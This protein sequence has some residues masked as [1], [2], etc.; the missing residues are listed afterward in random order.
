MP[1]DFAFTEEQELYRRTL[2]DYFAKVLTPK[3]KEISKARMVT[4]EVHK[5][6]TTQ[7]LLGLLV[8]KEFGGSES[9]Y[10]TFTIATEELTKA[11][12]SGLVIFGIL[13]GPVCARV[14]AAYGT[15]ELKQEVLPKVVK[16]GWIT[17]LHNTEPGCGTDF[18]DHNNR[19]E[20][21][22]GLRG[23]R[24][25]TDADR[26]SRDYEVWWRLHHNCEDET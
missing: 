4:S 7:G 5:A 13:Y 18:R 24:G 12:P 21:Q 11:D 1:L 14:I 3:S 25:E 6:M 9:D 22:W 15:A 2:K 19:E 8:P 20:D 10:V 16:E 23:E 26:R 17:P